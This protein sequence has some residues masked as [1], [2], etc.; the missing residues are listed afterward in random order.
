MIRLIIKLNYQKQLSVNEGCGLAEQK[1]CGKGLSNC[2]IVYERCKLS[3]TLEWPKHVQR[4]TYL[5]DILTK[6]FQRILLQP[7]LLST[8]SIVKDGFLWPSTIW[9]DVIVYENKLNF[10]CGSEVTILIWD[11]HQYIV[12]PSLLLWF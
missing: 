3:A 6:S 7:N 12:N 5:R 11:F 4:G 1:H 2:S 10:D 9:F 8:N